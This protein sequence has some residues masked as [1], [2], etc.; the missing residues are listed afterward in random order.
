MSI[1]NNDVFRSQLEFFFDPGIDMNVHKGKDNNE[2]LHEIITDHHIVKM[3]L[4][5]HPVIF[6]TFINDD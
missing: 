4:S 6:F 3:I 5:K 2:H 1:E